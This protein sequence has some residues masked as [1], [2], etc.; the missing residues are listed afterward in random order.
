[1]IQW[2]QESGDSYRIPATKMCFFLWDGVYTG[3]GIGMSYTLCCFCLFSYVH[4][5]SWD[6]TNTDMALVKFLAKKNGDLV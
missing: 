1:M 6:F 2:D 4:F 5:I 3:E